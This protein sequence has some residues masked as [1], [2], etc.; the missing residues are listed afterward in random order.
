MLLA[1]L[2]LRA[3]AIKIIY[4]CRLYSNSANRGHHIII[5][6]LFFAPIPPSVP[7]FPTKPIKIRTT[8][9]VFHRRRTQ[10][11]VLIS[12]TGYEVV[13]PSSQM[14]GTDNNIRRRNF[15]RECMYCCTTYSTYTTIPPISTCWL[16][17]SAGNIKKNT[18]RL[19]ATNIIK[20]K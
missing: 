12:S 19:N 4:T 3:R 20:N 11:S 16:C 14:G 5:H 9:C 10:Q 2:C 1:L 6:S 18:T 17:C 13:R 8:E 7:L 15:S